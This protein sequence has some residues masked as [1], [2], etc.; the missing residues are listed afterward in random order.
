MISKDQLADAML[1]ECDI[2]SHL[3]TKL[4]PAQLDYRPS[5]EQ[6]STL[7]LLQYL[8]IVGIAGSRCMAAGDFNLFKEFSERASTVT[9]DSFA[10]AMDKQK[11]ELRELFAGFDE[12][13]LETQAAPL[14]GG[15]E[16]PLGLA[17]ML[18][19]IKWLAA[20]KLQLFLYA[21]ASGATELGT[22]N[23]WAGVDPTPTA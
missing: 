17:I 5:A 9:L 15:G 22:A 11:K 1:R 21:K 7:E 3:H 14:P 6:R 20:Y 8:S 19:P 4:D 23:A 2:I 16:A 18:G 13:L 12:K 10:G